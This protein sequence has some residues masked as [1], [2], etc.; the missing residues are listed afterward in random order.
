MSWA[1]FG[2]DDVEKGTGINEFG[3]GFFEKN[4]VPNSFIPVPN[5]Y[6]HRPS[7]RNE[8]VSLAHRH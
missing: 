6:T 5:F 4:P 7:Q 3:T 1:D 8:N 2:V